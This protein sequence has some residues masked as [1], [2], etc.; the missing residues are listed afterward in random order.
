[1]K[2]VTRERPKTDR[3]ACPWLIRR[4]INPEFTFVRARTVLS[5]AV[6]PHAHSFDS[7]S[8]PFTNELNQ[9]TF[10]MLFD[11]CCLNDDAALARWAPT[12]HGAHV[13]VDIDTEPAG[14]QIETR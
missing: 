4:F 2:W 10:E 12:V 1:M 14:R 13:E 11:R 8:V 3:I 7:S 9:C 5:V 6:H